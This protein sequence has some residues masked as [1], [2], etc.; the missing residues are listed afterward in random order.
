MDCR[1]KNA[2]LM[3]FDAVSRWA[4]LCKNDTIKENYSWLEFNEMDFNNRFKHFCLCSM[5]R[6]SWRIKICVEEHV[7]CVILLDRIQIRIGLIFARISFAQTIN[8]FCALNVF[9]KNSIYINTR[10]KFLLTMSYPLLGEFKYWVNL[11]TVKVVI[12]AMRIMFS[13]LGMF[14][15]C[16]KITN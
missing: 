9:G 6:V 1:C 8:S 7:T 5:C 15:T 16:Y 4:D 2:L 3:C 13:H 14:D 11:N 12:G 10:V